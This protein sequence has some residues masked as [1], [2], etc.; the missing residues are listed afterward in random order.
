MHSSTDPNNDGAIDCEYCDDSDF[1]GYAEGTHRPLNGPHRVQMGWVAGAGIVDASA[2][3]TFTLSPL[4]SQGATGPQVA[5]IVASNGDPYYL[6]YR[7]PIGYDAY[8]ASTYYST[9]L[10]NETSIH[11][12]PGGS[13]NT[14]FIGSLGDGDTFTDAGNSLTIVQNSHSASGATF[15]VY[16]GMTPPTGLK[17]T[18]GSAQVALTWS[19]ATGATGYNVKRAAVS[20]GPY[21]TIATQ[22]AVTAYTD[23]GLANGTTYWYVVSALAGG[24]ETADSA[25]VSGTPQGIDLAATAV[26]N[27]PAATTPGSNS[28]APSGASASSTTATRRSAVSPPRS[29]RT[30][31]T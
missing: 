31:A 29:T 13:T 21:T 9:G 26:S 11:R 12:W 24:K 15:T 10:V 18:A 2:G 5:K 4:N 17:A 1:M 19:A 6:A 20:G 25:P 22:G 30:R 3:G 16:V 8:L 27:P 14:R 28:R 7:T 23:T